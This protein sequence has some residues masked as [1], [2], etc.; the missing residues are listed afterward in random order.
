MIL[1]D[2]RI[3]IMPGDIVTE[4]W[5]KPSV[6]DFHDQ[7]RVL[8]V[9]HLEIPYKD[10]SKD[11]VIEVWV[12]VECIHSKRTPARI[13]NQEQMK[14][15]AVRRIEDRRLGY[16]LAEM[17]RREDEA[18]AVAKLRARETDWLSTELKKRTE[19]VNQHEAA[20]RDYS[21]KIGELELSKSELQRAYGDA[22]AACRFLVDAV[23]AQTNEK[24]RGTRTRRTFN[25][26]MRQAYE[27]ALSVVER[28]R[29]KVLRTIA[30]GARSMEESL[31]A[32]TMSQLEERGVNLDDFGAQT[33]DDI[34]AAWLEGGDLN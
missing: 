13:G 21:R 30:R 27:E 16:Y 3:P 5:Y 20:A 31:I 8:S 28:A 22:L 11:P 34:A 23:D 26:D 29:R 1:D 15:A 12:N 6:P 25:A 7:F 9:W 24:I 4:G 2:L 14:A 32:L 19:L 33:V 10:A 18:Q 17:E